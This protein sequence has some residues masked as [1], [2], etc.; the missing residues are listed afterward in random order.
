MGRFPGFNKHQAIVI[1]IDLFNKVKISI[2]IPTFNQGNFIE[3]TIKSVITQNYPKLELIIIDGGSEDNTVDIIRKYEKYLKFWVS[4]RDKGQAHAINK[5]LTKCTG[6]IFNWLNSDDYLE[7]GSL[8][9]IAA[10]FADEQI[11]MVA[12]KVRTFSKLSE[13]IIPNQ[14]LSAKGLMCW[15]PG[16]KFVQ[17]GVWMRRDLLEKSG[18]ID[19]QYHYSF[20]WDLYIR[21]LYH[22]PNVKEL[23]D[24]LVHFRL[25]GDSKTQS[26]YEK[27]QMEQN[28]IIEK[29]SKTRGLDRLKPVCDFK[30]QQLG[31]TM[32]LNELSQSN[33]SFPKK[34]VK[35]IKN[36]KHFG[37]VS[38]SRQTLGALKAFALKKMI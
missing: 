25:H 22:F 36:L 33:I 37:K 21:Y 9:Q 17:P 8:H 31:W 4:E 26:M 16:V 32:F 34:I 13:E 27:F 38:Y 18:G 30:I 5:G 15:E 3:Q 12:G 35:I 11:N 6:D 2:V 28:L 24:L 20:D 10:A 29:L 23:D 1:K 19:E 14:K 7:P